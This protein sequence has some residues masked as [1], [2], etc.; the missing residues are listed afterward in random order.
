MKDVTVEEYTTLL[1]PDLF[2]EI[3]GYPRALVR[4]AIDRGLKTRGG[5]ITGIA[6][7]R[8]Q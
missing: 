7:C 2:A 4:L 6:F 5:K 8:L 1:T 3:F